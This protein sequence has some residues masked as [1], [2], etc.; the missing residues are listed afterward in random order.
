MKSS[1][2]VIV[3][4]LLAMA[5]LAASPSIIPLPKQSQFLPGTFTLCPP[6]P[7]PPVPGHAMTKILVDGSS[8]PT[9]QYLAALLAKST[10]YQFQIVTIT[11][12]SAVRGAIL[13]TTSNAIASLGSEG[14]EL[15]VAPDSVVIRAPGS[16]GGFYGVQ[17]LL[18]LLPPKI[19]S[20]HPVSG[21]AWTTPCI[22][23]QDQPRF[24][25]RGYM[26]DE[27][28][29]FFGKQEVKKFM[30]AMALQKMNTFH[31]HLVDDEGW[32]IQILAYP[33]LT[34]MGAWRNGLGT[35]NAVT[36]AQNNGIDFGQNPR[37]SSNTNSAGLY[38]GFYSQ[39]DIREI[40]AYAAQRHITI[41]P[42]IEMPCHSTA[43][44]F[45][46]PQFGCGNPGS[47]YIMD[48]NPDSSPNID[49]GDDLYCLGTN[50]TISFLQEVLTEVMGLFPGQYIHCGGDE[51][52]SSEDH[53]W[54]TYG[55][56]VAKMAALGITGTQSQKI[57]A[58]QHWFSTN[59]AAFIQANGHTMI[60]WTEF[61]AGGTVPNAALMDWET[62]T[63]S[64]AGV[65]ASNGQ[66]VVMVPDVDCYL[67]YYMS[68]NG[69]GEYP[70]AEP[71]FSLGDYLPLSKVY[72]F[73]PI[74]SGLATQYQSNILGA[75][76]SEFAED[77]PSTLNEEFKAFPRLCAMAELTWT[78]A[79]SKS[80]SSFTNR[81]VTH[82]QRL[83]A[84][85]MN[86][87]QTNAIAIG[88]WGPTVSS[89]SMTNVSFN[90]TPYITGAG[91]INLDFHYTS[92]SD[93]INIY[94]VTLLVNGMAT[95]TDN[96][97]YIGYAGLSAANL[98]YFILHLPSYIPGA[99][100]TI[101]ATFEGYGGTSSS[102]TVYMVN[103]N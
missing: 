46:Y 34:Q 31:W 17:S 22:Y 62:G 10:D 30:D 42:E 102:G 99:T 21:V 78:P 73:E 85:G 3:S 4:W 26:M 49:Y 76:C 52:I 59:M 55:P 27:S 95:D 91:D 25:W 28:R 66:P 83:A 7:N 68:T 100:Y 14:Y 23:V 15:T 87:D 8:L 40:V 9:G 24:S 94:S 57:V 5:C 39:N 63:N 37:V 32:R 45:A 36:S 50:T 103:W 86:Y 69:A 41:V 35:T 58:Y 75:E 47:A 54:T 18:Q 51:V 98:P 97:G 79:A 60:G 101:Q 12:T 43:G 29:H 80:F 11:N 38:G 96:T 19:L 72:N 74:P 88:T 90:L 16:A 71:Y 64:A 2:A 1:I 6:Q 93:A 89:T 65:T 48:V 44:L 61:E 81:L 84:I 67:N 77:I 56:D 20:L 13:I 82:E 92:G 33:L 70:V 53:Q